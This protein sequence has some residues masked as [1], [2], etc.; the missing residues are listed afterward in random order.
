VANSSFRNNRFLLNKLGEKIMSDT[1]ISTSNPTPEY[2]VER[3]EEINLRP[4]SGGIKGS[5]DGLLQDAPGCSTAIVNGLSQQL[6]HQMNL[7]VPDALVSFDDLNVDLGDAAYAYL[8][9]SAKQ[10]LQS[11]IQDRGAKMV[12]NSAYRTIAQQLL[13]Y[14]WGSGCGF[15]LVAL[16]GQ[17]NHQSGLALDI[18]DYHGWRPYLEAYG[19][20]WLG[21]IDPPHFD[22]VGG[23]TQDIRGTAMLAIQKLW[24]NNHPNQKIDEDS[25]YG[26]QTESA[27]MNSP[28]MGFAEAP[29][30]K[31]P[32]VLKLSRPLM[33]GSDVRKLQES[34]QRAGITVAVDGVFGP[35]T[36][37]AVK[38]FQQKKGLKADGIV[39]PKTREQLA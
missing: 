11:A 39:G 28:A 5:F 13:L 21:D 26:P 27:L 2:T 22:Y 15:S 4:R 35:G 6:I 7:I 9:P 12:V 38:E 8:Q 10:A 18:E 25:R 33:E 36:D 29:W 31:K 23:G 14:N 17:S 34:L 19:W 37:K 3:C 24:N 32:R 20:D 16:P 30:D 1:V